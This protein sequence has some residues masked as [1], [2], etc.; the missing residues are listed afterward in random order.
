VRVGVYDRYW[1]TGGG[2]EKFAAGIAAALAGDHDVDL[3]AHEPVDL[4]WLGERLHLDLSGLGVQQVPDH[5]G[6]VTA[7][8][9]AYDVFVN[10]SYRSGDP[11]RAGRGVYVVHF[12]GPRPTRLERARHRLAG[13]GA[14]RLGGGASVVL[15]EGFYLPEGTTRRPL[16]W[17]SG[18]A[19]LR[20][21]SRS[22][23]RVPVAVLL[24]RVLPPAVT[25]VEVTAEVDGK[26]VGR[27][28]VD[29]PASRLDRRRTSVLHLALDVEPGVPATV[30][31]RSPTW[32][33]AEAGIG[34][35]RRRL[36]AAVAGAYTGGGWRGAV[37]AAAVRVAGPGDG[38]E[39]LDSYDRVLANSRFTQTWTDRMWRRP[40]GILYPP[41]TQM[42]PGT[43]GPVVLSVGRFFLPGTGHNKKQLEMV[44]AF[45]RLYG[46]G[47]ADGWTYHLVGGCAPEHERYLDQIRAEA[48][49]LPVELHPD[50]S[51]AELADLYARASIFWHA[52]GLDEDPD[53]H[54]DRY[55]HFGITTVEAMSAGAVP[56][57]IDAAGQ[58]EIVEHGRGGFRFADLTGLV[59]HTRALIR[60]AALRE[61]LALAARQRAADFAW[62]PFVQRV[63]AEVAAVA[64]ADRRRPAPG[65]T[66]RSDPG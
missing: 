34:T 27:T 48:G 8:S 52:A 28:V 5:A 62:E 29:A 64:G 50:A 12:P 53:A 51:G 13:A 63:Q 45:R 66:T 20:V 46:S 39:F 44:R 61:R 11:S 18:E 32:V 26:T 42:A 14:D 15:D 19:T 31:L 49:D 35:D 37:A 57:V 17:T 55:E 16:R 43:K 38:L 21:T 4:A 24:A 1:S 40:S 58:A 25:P 65:R 9:A 60:D 23:A 3:V 59:E 6:G 22:A 30:V 36:G 56:V 33:P 41:I 10:A 47:E 54:P 2:G 7:A